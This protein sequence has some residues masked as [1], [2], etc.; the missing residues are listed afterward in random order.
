MLI[1]KYTSVL[2]LFMVVLVSSQAQQTPILSQYMMDQYQINPAFA[3][4]DGFLNINLTAHEQWVGFDNSP[5]THAVS[6]HTRLYEQSYILKENPVKK[7]SRRPFKGGR[8]GIGAAIFDDR[9][10]L[11]SRTG[12]QLTYAFHIPFEATQLSFGLSAN[13]FQYK[14]DL[15]EV[16]LFEEEDPY[17]LGYDGVMFI[18]DADFGVIF[19]S[20]DYQVGLSINHLFESAWKLGNTGNSKYQLLRHYYFNVNY[21]FKASP[22]VEI[23][24]Y[25]LLK[26][27]NDFSNLQADIN[28]TVR[29]KNAYWGGI[30]YR[31]KD[32]MIIMAGLRYNQFHFG[33]AFD[34]SFSTIRNYNYGSHEII[35]GFR[36]GD[37]A[38][39]FRWLNEM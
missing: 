6:F 39:R 16:I 10:G 37:P 1:N 13:A 15:D 24:P 7:K 25:L 17:L 8:I 11:I 23:M 4:H 29:Y 3:G 30:S 20:A 9:L 19:S 21:T 12:F 18:P 35:A 38:R 31:T 14:L 5:K 33:Y 34:Y 22:N 26:G 2:L 32:A 36:L 27:S 28:L